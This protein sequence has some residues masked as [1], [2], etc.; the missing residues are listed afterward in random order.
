MSA[1]VFACPL[2]PHPPSGDSVISTHV[3][4]T[5]PHL[6]SNAYQVLTGN[7]TDLV[8]VLLVRL[9]VLKK[10]LELNPDAFPG[11][12]LLLIQIYVRQGRPRRMPRL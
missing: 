7:L 5:R 6:Q 12:I 2:I 11:P 4:L 9:L 1:L 3:R 8:A 10:S